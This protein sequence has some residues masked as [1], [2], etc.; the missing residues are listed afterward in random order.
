MNPPDFLA[1]QLEPRHMVGQSV[2]KNDWF[3]QASIEQNDREW[4]SCMKRARGN[5]VGC[6][7]A[8]KNRHLGYI[9]NDVQFPVLIPNSMIYVNSNT[10]PDLQVHQIE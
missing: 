1:V 4:V 10:I 9:E 5:T 2:S 6:E 8:L 7:F 3:G